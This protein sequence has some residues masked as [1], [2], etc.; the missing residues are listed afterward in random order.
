M[1]LFRPGGRGLWGRRALRTLKLAFTTP[2]RKKGEKRYSKVIDASNQQLRKVISRQ[3]VSPPVASID[4]RNTH[5]SSRSTT[6]PQKHEAASSTNR[7]GKRRHD[8][9]KRGG[10]TLKLSDLN[11]GPLTVS[12]FIMR[13]MVLS[14]SAPYQY[15]KPLTSLRHTIAADLRHGTRDYRNSPPLRGAEPGR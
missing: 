15:L 10:S 1:S 6:R 9:H 14:S 11:R 2:D 7:P 13:A 12:S 4:S 8:S 5:D 3:P